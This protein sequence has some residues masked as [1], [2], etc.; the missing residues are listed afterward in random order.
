MDSRFGVIE[1]CCGGDAGE[2]LEF[3]PVLYIFLVL[4][5][6]DVTLFYA[7]LFS[8]HHFDMQNSHQHYCFTV[9]IR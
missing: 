6:R 9:K 7:A 5:F 4:F 1:A 2:L 3:V 8:S